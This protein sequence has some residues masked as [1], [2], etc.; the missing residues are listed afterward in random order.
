M[1]NEEYLIRSQGKAL[2][3]FGILPEQFYLLEVGEINTALEQR[4][5]QAREKKEM[6]RLTN[7]ILARP[8]F[9]PKRAIPTVEQ[10]HPFPWDK[11]RIDPVRFIPYDEQIEFAIKKGKQ[12]WIP[13]HWFEQSENYKHYV[14]KHGKSRGNRNAEKTAKRSPRQNEKVHPVKNSE[15]SQ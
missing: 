11:D 13:N 5:L 7:Y 4:D 15:I 8:N 9:D 6:W 1:T 3:L 10:F 12:D 2:A 14:R